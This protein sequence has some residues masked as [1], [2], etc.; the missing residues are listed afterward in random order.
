[1]CE[2]VHSLG[3]I[4]MQANSAYN[5]T[6]HPSRVILAQYRFLTARSVLAGRPSREYCLD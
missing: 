2:P 4:S 5:Q 1:M 3:E 6:G